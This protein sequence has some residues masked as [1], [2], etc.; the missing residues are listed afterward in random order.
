MDHITTFLSAMK[1]R[2]GSGLIANAKFLGALEGLIRDYPHA[3]IVDFGAGIGTVTLFARQI[4]DFTP[5]VAVEKDA[6]CREQ[7]RANCAALEG[8]ALHASLSERDISA[9]SLIVI[10]DMTDDAEL[11]ILLESQPKILLI[12]G[13]RYSQRLALLRLAL[14]LRI[15]LV[16]SSF[17][18]FPLSLKGG[19]IFTAT[20]YTIWTRLSLSVSVLRVMLTRKL[21]LN[22][23]EWEASRL[24]LERI[25]S[26][27]SK[28]SGGRQARETSTGTP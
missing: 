26:R 22:K 17:L 5:I 19:A 18:G 7:F 2:E 20:R 10:D 4:S 23:L 15:G 24:Y 9:E 25:N 28:R 3:P 6:W 14:I 16:Y 27:G 21:K 12:E 11:K 13:H 8:V 1:K